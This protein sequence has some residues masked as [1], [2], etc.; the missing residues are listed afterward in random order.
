M[1][2]GVPPSSTPRQHAGTIEAH[3]CSVVLRRVAG[4]V[5]TELFLHCRPTVAASQAWW[6]ADAIY[7]SIV[8]VLE[9]EGVDFGS[10]VV[11][12]VF[13]R[14]LPES[15]EAVRDARRGVVLAH[16]GGS[17]PAPATTEI[18][19][20][21]LDARACLEVMVQA[22]VP[23]PGKARRESIEAPSACDCV[24]CV[25]AHAHVLYL[26]QEIRFFAGGLCGIGHDAY[27]QTL[28]MF[29]HAERLL[30][31]AG[32][33][34][35][36]VVRT[37][38]YLRHMER[39]YPQ[40]N[41]ARREFFAARSIRPVPA[42]TGIGGG[43]ASQIHDLCLGLYAVKSAR[44]IERTVMSSPTLNEAAEYGADFARG[45]KVVQ[46]NDVTLLVSGTASIDEQ[47]RT[48]H[49]GDLDGQ[50]DRMLRNVGA[51]LERQGATVD[52]V[53]SA[54]TYLKHPSD[55]ERLR[56]RL[57]EAGF[58]GFPHALVGAQVCRPD[59]LCETEAIAVVPTGPGAMSRSADGANSP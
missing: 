45:M 15:L 37:W 25:R 9:A 7:R 5:A 47:G 23:H 31:Q 34:F 21:P 20:P 24:E 4:P 11:E 38:I 17:S 18:E 19:Q 3:G 29:E 6:Q 44:P 53:V 33:E 13:L 32:M 50:V 28:G 48:V 12:T 2:A 43:P 16:G 8:D 36:D 49:A 26:G 30:R 51:L 58:E 27:E 54:I 52:D 39:D 41:R 42:S 40:L 59:L 57:R 55:T 22:V 10:V 46:S 14:D 1:G 56:H 35:S